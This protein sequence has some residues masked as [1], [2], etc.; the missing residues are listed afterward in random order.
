MS[1]AVKILV[2]ARDAQTYQRLLELRREVFETEQKIPAELQVDTID[3]KAIH[4][5]IE[6]GDRVVACGRAYS[7]KPS[8]LEV[9]RVCV[10]ASQ[11]SQGLGAAIIESAIEFARAHG[12][13]SVKLGAQ[14]SS[15]EFYSKLGFV[16][17]GEVYQEVGLPHVEMSLSLGASDSEGV[18]NLKF[19]LDGPGTH[20][21][22]FDELRVVIS[23]QIF[24]A[25]QSSGLTGDSSGPA[26]QQLI[27]D[28]FEIPKNPDHGD[29]ALPAVKLAKRLGISPIDLAKK[30][31]SEFSFD[32]AESITQVGPFV[33]FR[34]S[35][36]FIAE[37][38]VQALV[39]EEYFN[40]Q[41]LFMPPRIMLE[42]SQPNTHKELHVGHMRNIC[43]GLALTET[44]KYVGVPTVTATF[45]GDVGTHVAKC[46]WYLKHHNQEPVPQDARG[47]WLGAMYTKANNKLEEIAS[48][49]E[50]QEATAVMSQ[51]LKQLERKEGE[52]YDLWKETRAWSI[53]QMEEAYN[54]AEL[55]FD[56]WFWESEVDSDSVALVKQ[57]HKEGKLI[58]SEGAIGMD[59]T[60][61][62]LGFC[63]LLK[64]D[65]N[66]LY[67][68]K[69]LFL[70]FR[71]FNEHELDKSI[72]L[73][74]LR[75]SH[76]FKQVFKVLEHI[77]FA[78]AADCYHL[79]YNYVELP[80]GPMSSRKGNIVAINSL[81]NGMR[82]YIR[83]HYLAKHVGIWPDA[84][85]QE[86]ADCIGAGAIKYAMNSYEPG[87]KVVFS[88]EEWLKLDGQSGPYIQYC[89]VRINSLIRK[90]EAEGI[91]PQFDFSLMTDEEK[92]ILLKLNEFNYIALGVCKTFKTNSL[93]TYL[94]EVA[95]LFNSYYANNRIVTEDKALSAH[96]LM[97][98]KV[99]TLVLEHG[100]RLLGIKVP[101]RM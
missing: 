35:K 45:P 67:G 59:L 50:G 38:V 66:G 84:E 64:S 85:I 44:F 79:P 9:G 57:L 93:C 30:I 58:E 37:Q 68:T 80:D 69:D 71:K 96:R 15:E 99:I 90:G 77:G 72:Y 41:L 98:S 63:M 62:N 22:Q 61:D 76:H 95:K 36:K 60:D 19:P 34:F 43:L 16:R 20:E 49:P 48:L 25:L 89:A 1:P 31:S 87:S 70:A 18:S 82:D 8:V 33:N 81:I 52:Y 83:D 86:V 13:S 6:Q 14:C 101:Q 12:F 39:S 92:L 7:T 40:R 23:K 2:P 78:H 11:R 97:F 3:P 54:W 91:A 51:I 10:E 74:D 4:F 56:A 42:F 88:L 28:L 5:F 94:Y 24:V 100:L 47:A 26:I 75:Q 53:E 21:L 17:C 32:F 65:G 27:Y 46:L 73:V 55:K 29:L